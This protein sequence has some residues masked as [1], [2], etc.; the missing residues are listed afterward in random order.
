MIAQASTPHM[1]RPPA[2]QNDCRLIHLPKISDPHGRGSLTVVEGNGEIPFPIQRAYWVYDVPG[3]ERRWGHAYK[4][5]QELLGGARK[6]RELHIPVDNVVQDWFWW[7]TMGEPTFDKSRYPDPKGMIGEL[8][9]NHFHLMIS[10]WPFFRPGSGTYVDMERQGFFIDKTKVACFHPAG[11]ALYDAC[12]PRVTAFPAF[13]GGLAGW[14][15]R[16]TPRPAGRAAP[17]PDEAARPGAF[18]TQ[19]RAADTR[20]APEG[21]T[22]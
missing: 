7:N 1:L 4:T 12:G 16:A 20:R 14:P 11:Q 2:S 21:P 10:V 22:R 9:A 17:G 6:Y 18:D 15:W 3:G 5:Q 13:A 19:P 8:H